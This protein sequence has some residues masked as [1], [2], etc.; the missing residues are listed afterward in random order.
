MILGVIAMKINV[1]CAIGPS[2][3]MITKLLQLWIGP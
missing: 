2:M 1:A 3:N